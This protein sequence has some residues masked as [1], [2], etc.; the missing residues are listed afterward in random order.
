MKQ[1]MK[2]TPRHPFWA[3]FFGEVCERGTFF[4]IKDIEK[5]YLLCQNGIGIRKGKG[6]G[7]RG[8]TFPRRTL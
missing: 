8:G 5:G 7:P 4:S 2:M 1:N 6:V 3:T